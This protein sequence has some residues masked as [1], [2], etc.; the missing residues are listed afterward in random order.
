MSPVTG[1]YDDFVAPPR[2]EQ[3]PFD[4]QR[5]HWYAYVIGVVPV[6]VPLSTDTVCP[7]CAV[8]CGFGCFVA[9]G[10]FPA[11]AIVPV[12]LD[13]ADARPAEL[14]AVTT[15]R[16]V[17]PTSELPRV[18]VVPVAPEMSPQL[19]PELLQRCQTNA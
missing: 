2:F 16:I 1:T 14:E 12:G 4:A 5:C 17:F 8:P 19:L 9:L 6:Q 13:A 18:Y 7:A 11:A 10:A 15:T 3:F